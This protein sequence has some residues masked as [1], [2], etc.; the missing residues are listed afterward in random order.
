MVVDGHLVHPQ[1]LSDSLLG[2]AQLVPVRLPL[3]EILALIAL[4]GVS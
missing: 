4:G 2:D 3:I 1:S